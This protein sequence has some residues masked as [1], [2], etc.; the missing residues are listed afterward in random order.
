MILYGVHPVAEALRSRARRLSR[1]YLRRG[2]L[3][4]RLQEI[5]RLAR[6][7]GVPLRFEPPEVLDKKAGN[8]RH[9]G[10]VAELSEIAYADL[11][12][13]LARRPDLLLALDGVEDPHNLGAVLR[14]AEAAGVQ[15]VLL[16]ERR[17]CGITPAV[18]RASAGAALQVPIVQIGNLVQT[19]ERLKQAGLWSVGLDVKGDLT[20]DQL[21]AT[22]PLV[23][24][25]GSEH[26]G[27]RRLVK[28]HCDY[29]VHLPMKGRVE[30]L[31]LSVATGILIYQIVL[32]RL[33]IEN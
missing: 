10:V 9:Q 23:L 6:E 5:L 12:E 21:D 29:L 11:E 28:E 32:R 13:L 15:G 31:N 19:L 27:L 1:L 4:G 17:A 18:V 22:L 7:S 14:T 25:A 24:V 8:A 16:P 30:S 2:R 33:N 26:T 20:P 3:G